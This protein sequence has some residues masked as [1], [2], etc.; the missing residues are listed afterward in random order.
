MGNDILQLEASGQSR[1]TFEAAERTGSAVVLIA[2]Q[3]QFRLVVMSV[4]L[5]PVW[6]SQLDS[7]IYKFAL[8]LQ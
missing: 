5:Q 6:S 3:M 8:V 2:L 1:V 7:K 4:A